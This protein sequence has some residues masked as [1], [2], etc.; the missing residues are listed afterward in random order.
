MKQIIE[1]KCQTCGCI[2]NVKPYRKNTSRFCSTKCWTQSEE[3]RFIVK[4]STTIRSRL[5]LFRTP[6]KHGYSKHIF[7]SLWRSIKDRCYNINNNSY[8]IYGGR[9]IYVC[10]E[11]KNNPKNFI[12]WS[13]SNGYEK[14]LSIDRINNDGNYE[15]SNCRFT[16]MKNQSR[17]KRNN[18]KY[19][20]KTVAEWSEIL[21]KN[22][23]TIYSRIK[24]GISIE[25]A[26]F[27]NV[28]ENGSWQKT[29]YIEKNISGKFS[30]KILNVCDN[31]GGTDNQHHPVC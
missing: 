22:P 6:I 15:P 28:L 25:K 1:K 12:E 8:G 23:Q 26:I 16:N 13:L 24:K 5:G 4:V 20:D 9:G 27:D 29:R 10:D 3:S 7:H 2:Y 30:K 17:N 14:G 11:W 31:C 18:I 21:N 19:K